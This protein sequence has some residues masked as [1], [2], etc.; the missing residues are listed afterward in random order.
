[1]DSRAENENRVLRLRVHLVFAGVPDSCDSKADREDKQKLRIGTAFFDRNRCLPYASARSCIVCEETLSDAQESDLVPGS[2]G[3]DAGW[4]L[5]HG[6]AAT[7][8]S[9]PLHRLRN[10]RN[11]CPISDERGV[12]I[13][14]VGETRNPKN[15]I[16]LPD[17]YSG[18]G[19]GQN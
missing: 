1:V 12:R 16:F 14:S 5:C 4:K 11:K 7:L 3:N 6:E 10:L 17:A 13:T 18:Y 15:Q 19:S 9:R 2:A 8:E